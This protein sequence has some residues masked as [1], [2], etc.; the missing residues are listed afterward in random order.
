MSN[1]YRCSFIES[2]LSFDER[3]MHAQMPLLAEI[4]SYFLLKL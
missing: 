1:V 2:C 3:R 4:E